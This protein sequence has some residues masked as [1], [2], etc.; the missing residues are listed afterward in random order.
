M[1]EATRV[2]LVEDNQ[3]DAR[4]VQEIL[5]EVEGARFVLRRVGSLKD[6]LGEIGK[7]DVDAVLL[8]LG[9]PDSQG[10]DTLDGVLRDFPTLPVIVLTGLDDHQVGMEAIRS[11]AQDYIVKGRFEAESLRR[12]IHYA[13][14]RQT[15][16]N[17]LHEHLEFQQQ[18][19]DALP[20]PVFYLDRTLVVIGCNAEFESLMSRSRHDMLG[21]M[22]GEVVPSNLMEDFDPHFPEGGENDRREGVI[23][24]ADANGVSRHL[25]MRR[26]V[27]K[28]RDGNPAGLVVTF[29][30]EASIPKAAP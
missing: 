30:S 27:F 8:D 16:F 5:R 13:I 26:S 12:A 17:L 11:G 22:V 9:L 24:L 25:V 1:E 3:T 7:G 29:V 19:I 10:L 4:Y 18:M 20:I 21:R 28:D 2:L 6:A 14:D 23:T 15:S